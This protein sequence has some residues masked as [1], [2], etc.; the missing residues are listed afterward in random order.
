MNLVTVYLII[1]VAG[2]IICWCL[3]ILYLNRRYL[4]P[5]MKRWAAKLTLRDCD[6]PEV[7]LTIMQMSPHE[8]LRTEALH[9]Y[10]DMTY[11]R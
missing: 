4:D 8:P 9:R 1:A 3:L 11:D 2:I 5:M 7:L 10:L 6:D